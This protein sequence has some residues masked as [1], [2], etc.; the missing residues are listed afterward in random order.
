MIDYVTYKKWISVDRCTM[1]TLI[2]KTDQ[3]IEEF[4]EDV[5]KL[6]TYSFIA[7]IAK[8][9]FQRFKKQI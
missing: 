8:D 2:K 4:T 7:T 1:E 6:K 5:L 9:I 3:F